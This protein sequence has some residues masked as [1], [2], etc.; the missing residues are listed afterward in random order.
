MSRLRSIVA[1]SCAAGLAL[2][3]SSCGIDLRGDASRNELT[4]RLTDELTKRGFTNI[5]L[6]NVNTKGRNSAEALVSVGG[7]R[8]RMAWTD[9]DRWKLLDGKVEGPGELTADLIKEAAAVQGLRFTACALRSALQ[10]RR[11]IVRPDPAYSPE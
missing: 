9:G 10:A 6:G 1:L 5:A 2:T 7:C 8:L 11:L 3:L 4:G